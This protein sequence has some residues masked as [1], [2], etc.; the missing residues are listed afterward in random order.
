MALLPLFFLLFIAGCQEQ[1]PDGLPMVDMKIGSRTFVLEVARTD[2]QQEKGLM[3]RDS[4]PADHGMIFPF[5]E[6]RVLGFW[7]KDT[8]FPL[9]IIFTDSKGRVVTI[10]PMEAYDENNTS[11]DFP[12]RYAIELNKGAAKAAGVKVGDVLDIPPPARAK[13]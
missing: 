7:M 6:E 1:S 9:D 13:D 8:R 10:H 2:A 11:S 5:K 4:M 3:K 12:A